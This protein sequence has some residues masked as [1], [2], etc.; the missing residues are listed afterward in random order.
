MGLMNNEGR[1]VQGG[2]RTMGCQ[3]GGMAADDQ[4]YRRIIGSEITP[5][6]RE[7]WPDDQERSLEATARLL[8]DD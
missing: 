5:L 8:D 4:W 6:L 2:F 3:T 1:P 7:Y